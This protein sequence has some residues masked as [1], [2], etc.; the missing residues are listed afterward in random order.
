MNYDLHDLNAI[1]K[2]SFSNDK[3]DWSSNDENVNI[4]KLAVFKKSI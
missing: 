2:S 3:T 1:L 4:E